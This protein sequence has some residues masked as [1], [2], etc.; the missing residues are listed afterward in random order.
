MKNKPMITDSPSHCANMVLAAGANV[1]PRY[2]AH[3]LVSF[4]RT[5]NAR[6]ASW[7]GVRSFLFYLFVNL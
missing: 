4:G 3:G 1:S 7:C 6:L 2:E 5:W